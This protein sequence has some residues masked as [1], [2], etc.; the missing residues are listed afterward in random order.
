MPTPTLQDLHD[1]MLAYEV[2]AHRI[3]G[4]LEVHN[5][6]L[7]AILA[8]AVPPP[9]PSP[10]QQALDQVVVA[11]KEQTAA[12]HALPAALVDALREDALAELGGEAMDTKGSG[13]WKS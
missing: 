6:K 3:L 1:A 5:E 9:G 10:V 11:L 13:E 2:V 12:V 7:D 4:C 8:A